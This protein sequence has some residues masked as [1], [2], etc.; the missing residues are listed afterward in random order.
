[1]VEF[2]IAA[3][4]FFVVIFGTIDF[5]RAAYEY[6]IIASSA[7]EGARVAIIQGNTNDCVLRRVVDSSTSM[8]LAG[9]SPT[10]TGAPTLCV[11]LPCT[12]G[13]IAINATGGVRTCI[14]IPC[15]T[16]TVSVTRT[17]RPVT[18][19]LARIVG[20]TISLSASSTMVVER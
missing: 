18:P 19:L 6:N 13:N 10:C 4:I 14:S 3:L 2:A 11:V 20:N 8:V 17:Y 9:G 5:G 15:G 7:R 12:S 1:M 16:V